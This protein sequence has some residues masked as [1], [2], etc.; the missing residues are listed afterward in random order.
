[1]AFSKS[2]VSK[3]AWPMRLGLIMAS[4]PLRPR[5]HLHHFQCTE[6]MMNAVDDEFKGHPP[7]S[8]RKRC[9]TIA[10][11]R[12]D[13][14]IPHRSLAAPTHSTKPRYSAKA[15]A[16]S[17]AR[18]GATNMAGYKLATYQTADCPRAGLVIDD[19]VFDAA[20]L[21]GKSAYATVL[22]ILEDWK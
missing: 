17:I 8:D 14:P 12:F 21:T 1:M 9:M 5:I 18:T 2:G 15:C 10:Q 11:F 4:S 6:W 22:G 19:K 13:R 20:K 7:G 16:S 3:V